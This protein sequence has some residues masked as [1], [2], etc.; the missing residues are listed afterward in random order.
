MIAKRVESRGARKDNFGR[1][2]DYVLN[3]KGLSGEALDTAKQA[4]LHDPFGA[5]AQYVLDASDLTPASLK[6][7]TYDPANKR[8]GDR[9]VGAQAVNCGTDDL[10]EALEIITNIQAANEAT[11]AEKTY[12]MVFSFPEGER[13]TLEQLRLIEAELCEA[14]GYGD[15]QRISAIHDDTKFLHV[16]VAINKIHPETYR[17]IAPRF[18]KLRMMEKCIELEERLGLQPDFH[19]RDA[20]KKTGRDLE[21][22][23]EAAKA[24]E[25]AKQAERHSGEQSFVTWMAVQVK[26]ELDRDLASAKDWASVHA[27]FDKHG[28]V[29][30]PHGAGLV[31]GDPAAKV[32]VKAS[33]V[34]RQ[35]SV[36]AMTAKFGQ[37]Q[38][39]AQ[40]A[41]LGKAPEK[42]NAPAGYKRGPTSARA[43]AKALYAR[44]EAERAARLSER[45]NKLAEFGAGRD[46]IEAETK[47]YLR[48]R[49]EQIKGERALRGYDKKKAYDRLKIERI[50]RTTTD[51]AERRKGLAEIKAAHPLLNWQSFLERE[52]V[53]GDEAALTVLRDRMAKASDLAA[54]ILTAADKSEA[55]NVVYQQLGPKVSKDGDLTYRLRDGGVVVDRAT[56]VRTDTVTASSAF[57]ALSLAADK[58]AGQPLEVRGSNA[59]KAAIIEVA[60]IE[61][62]A[63]TFADKDMEQARQKAVQIR[64]GEQERTAAGISAAQNYANNRNAM[65]GKVDDVPPHRLWQPTD[66]GPAE[67]AGRRRFADGTEAV[68]L[69]IGAEVAVM[70]VTGNQA[71][72]ASKWTVGDL[73]VT[74]NRGR[75]KD[76]GRKEATQA[77]GVTR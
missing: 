20:E 38:P 19:G 40:N 52:A 23:T 25:E 59:F 58:Y 27:A 33:S 2:T 68:L 21:P 11:K 57:L 13:P 49:F 34:D 69:K 36:K 66:A 3:E 24:K 73:V 26:P 44:Y 77:Q 28:L 14:I 37:F 71:A 35:L 39:K 15:H 29:I 72:K 48:R 75:F 60:A 31:I 43:E 41:D 55:R 22:T 30:K 74:D 46:Q 47:A 17:N 42:T 8:E 50:A 56:H 54:D 12:H 16:H 64:E 4:G 65:R 51:R 61:G 6:F 1:L 7:D 45:D 62:F 18:D 53:R 70:P 32:F 76:T 63:V 67:Y 9:V 10:G 5:V